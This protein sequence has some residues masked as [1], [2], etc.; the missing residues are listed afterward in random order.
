M[1]R[2]HRHGGPYIVGAPPADGVGLCGCGIKPAIAFGSADS[3]GAARRTVLPPSVA[4]VGRSS[5]RWRRRPGQ[6]SSLFWP[7]RGPLQRG[8]SQTRRLGPCPLA[9]QQSRAQRSDL[10][11]VAHSTDYTLDY[12]CSGRRSVG[13][14]STG[15]CGVVCGLVTLILVVWR[16][17]G[18]GRPVGR[19][20][21][22]GRR[23]ASGLL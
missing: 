16:R 14:G 19:C 2:E 20:C 5:L 18:S 7:P 22:A 11:A 1:F 10:C 3:H 23:G 8:S 17:L 13:P 15:R 4:K 12:T 9:C 6:W 21:P